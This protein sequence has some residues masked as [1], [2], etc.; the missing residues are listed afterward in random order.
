M[1]DV[2]YWNHE[3]LKVFQTNQT[4][5]WSIWRLKELIELAI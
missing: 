5:A 4:I 2:D 3:T 1:N